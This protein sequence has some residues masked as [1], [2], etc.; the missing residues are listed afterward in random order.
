MVRLLLL[1]VIVAAAVGGVLSWRSQS[2]PFNGRE[3]RI[4]IE[5]SADEVLCE[6]GWKVTVEDPRTF[7]R[8]DVCTRDHDHWHLQ[9]VGQPYRD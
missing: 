8:H 9:V 2:S 1:L 4:V 7:V 3:Q 6:S 5:K